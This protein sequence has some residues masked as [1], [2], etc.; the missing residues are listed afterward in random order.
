TKI[1]LALTQG[2]APIA[3][4]VPAR[5]GRS[6]RIVPLDE[7]SVPAALQP[8]FI[9]GDVSGSTIALPYDLVAANGEV[10]IYTANGGAAI[11]GLV[12]GESYYVVGRAGN[13]LQ[14]ARTEGGPAISLDASQATGRAHSLTRQDTQ[15]PGD[16]AL[17]TGIRVL[18]PRLGAIRGVAVIANNSDEILA[19]GGAGAVGG[20]AG[21][22]VAGNV[23]VVNV[24]TDAFIG[25]LA[26]V[27]D[28]GNEEA[29][30]F[31]SVAVQAGGSFRQ[32]MV[33]AALGAGTV[34]VGVSAAVDVVDLDQDAQIRSGA[35]VRA[36]NDVVVAAIGNEDVTA[37]S[38]ALGGGLVGVAVAVTV[39]IVNAHTHALVA[40]GATVDA[41]NNVIVS[42]IDDSSYTTVTG[43]IGVGFVGVG[44]GVAVVTTTKST[45]ARIGA[46]ATVDAR[47]LRGAFGSIS[48]DGYLGKGALGLAVTAQSSQ[49]LFGLVIGA[50][51]GF[52]GAAGGVGVTLLDVTTNASI[53]STSAARTR[54]NAD[55]AGAGAWQGVLVAA[56]DTTDT[57]TIAAAL[58][59]GAVAVSGAVDIGIAD[60][61]VTTSIGD[62]AEVRAAHSLTMAATS[63]REIQTFAAN[64]AGGA[65]GVGASVSV[66]TVGGTPSGSYDDGG[67]NGP[68]DALGSAGGSPQQQ[69]D[70]V[71]AGDGDSGN[72]LGGFR[73]ILS[74]AED[75]EG[76]S[77]NVAAMHRQN[78]IAAASGAVRTAETGDSLVAD[79]FATAPMRGTSSR[80][81]VN[82][83]IATGRG[84]A[85]LAD[86]DDSYFGLAGSASAGIAGV[87]AAVLVATLRPTIEA[88]VSTGT[89]LRSGGD[90]TVRSRYAEDT[91][92]LAF[93]G[94]VGVVG[95]GGQ[96]VVISSVVDQEAHIDDGVSI[97][98]AYGTVAVE[99]IADRTLEAHTIGL[100]IAGIAVG[101]SVAIVDLA[102]DGETSDTIAR[103]GDVLIGSESPVGGVRVLA[104][105]DIRID[106]S[107]LALS[108]GVAFSAT[109]AGADIEIPGRTEATFA[110][111]VIT[112]GAVTV[113][114]VSRS[115][116]S[117]LIAAVQGS[118]G[119]T[120][121]AF[122]TEAVIS[123]DTLASTAAG[124]VIRAAGA[125]TVAADSRNRADAS[126]ASGSF[127]GFFG[128]A[129]QLQS[130]TVSGLT[131]ALL[132]ST[133]EQS[134]SVTVT[135]VGENRA[136]ANGVLL[137]LGA[138]TISG[139]LVTALVTEAAAVRATASGPFIHSLGV[140]AVTATIA[141]DGGSGGL[142]GGNLAKAF[143]T[144]VSG[145]LFSGSAYGAR[146]E[147]RGATTATLDSPV[148]S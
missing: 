14:L 22:G 105:S 126:I 33:S 9:P 2:G 64:V 84:I 93:A 30:A 71:V 85:V 99:A 57:L 119:A 107:A 41:G 27:N 35:I 134:G 17:A 125:V 39:A 50:G 81:G 121:G 54:I 46:G 37:A 90:I 129:A 136:I 58:A 145:A 142:A 130:A 113:R 1:R 8:Y 102:G 109:G 131:E 118:G 29:S 55:Q 73:D 32:L 138:A 69:A 79:S 4:S 61:A 88:G 65:V 112:F 24:D 139:A 106:A 117:T 74:G 143:L 11:G 67:D 140:V 147:L 110:G 115:T 18:S 144:A 95:V 82:A 98:A 75:E 96:I 10:L 78:G 72:G 38:A 80:I 132:R 114:A 146:A 36:Q 135:A 49:R 68:R 122:V 120:I 12:D 43:G 128:A 23:N 133:V 124:T 42:A 148:Y 52:V 34:G 5:P 97:P 94:Q 70:T 66:W 137:A 76:A 26:R 123:R 63:V 89:V 3:I 15:P 51:G 141:T 31:Q 45:D 47:A 101:G 59:V 108:V 83:L 44:V 28:L 6:H 56:H 53:D 92:G 48:D 16:P 127:A 103:I 13:S 87:G 20:S 60:I 86:A 7:A 91:F 21:V 100:Q 40:G 111:S 19:I 25:R 116:V 62:F 104:D 77:Q